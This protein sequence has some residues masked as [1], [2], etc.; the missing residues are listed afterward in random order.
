LVVLFIVYNFDENTP[1]EE[2][3]RA[4][5]NLERQGKM[6]LPCCQQPEAGQISM[7]SGISA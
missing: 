5:D 3:R 2:T 1:M 6:L 4:L 7:A